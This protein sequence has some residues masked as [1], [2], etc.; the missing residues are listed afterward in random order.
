MIIKQSDIGIQ[1]NYELDLNM[2]VNVLLY[3]DDI[4]L[5]AADEQDLQS[6]IVIVEAWCKK[7]KVEL[8]L[9]KTNVMHIRNSNKKQSNF[10][11]QPSINI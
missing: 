1:F 6:F 9:T 11:A 5:I 4:V 2:L 7:W 8:N 3:A 10:W